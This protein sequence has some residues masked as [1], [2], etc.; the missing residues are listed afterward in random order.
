MVINLNYTIS[1]NT[2]T[3]SDFSAEESDVITLVGIKMG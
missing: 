1:G 3:L 2:L